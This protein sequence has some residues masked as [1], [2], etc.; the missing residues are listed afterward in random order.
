M[1]RSKTWIQMLK[2]NPRPKPTGYTTVDDAYDTRIPLHN[3]E[4]F[5]HGINFRAKFIGSLEVPRPSSRVEIVASMRRIRYEFRAKSIRK[6]KCHITISVDGVKVLKRR[7]RDDRRRKRGMHVDESEIM[8]MNHPIY[9][10]FYVSHDSLDLKIFSYIVRD[11]PENTFKCNVFKALKK[12][13]ALHI[14]R[15]LG[16][17]F[18]VCHKL[19]SQERQQRSS[20]QATSPSVEN[21]NENEEAPSVTVAEPPSCEGTA[22]IE[23]SSEDQTDGAGATEEQHVPVGLLGEGNEGTSAALMEMSGTDEDLIKLDLKHTILAPQPSEPLIIRPSTHVG[24]SQQAST[25][26]P[27]PEHAPSGKPNQTG[28]PSKPPNINLLNLKMWSPADISLHRAATGRQQTG[29]SV[30]PNPGAGD[31]TDMFRPVPSNPLNPFKETEAEGES[32]LVQ[33]LEEQLQAERASR[34]ELEEQL[35]AERAEKLQLETQLKTEK[36]DR[37]EAQARVHHLLVQNQK[38]LSHVHKLMVDLQDLQ[39][40]QATGPFQSGIPVTSNGTMIDTLK[41]IQQDHS[42]SETTPLVDVTQNDS[43]V[44]RQQMPLIVNADAGTPGNLSPDGFEVAVGADTDVNSP[45][46]DVTDFDR[47]VN[48]WEQ[49]DDN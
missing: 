48:S 37:I 33:R 30:A 42:M 7:R 25:P 18:E 35:T 3:E 40:L 6:A 4:A 43:D 8:M 14:V 16:Q 11:G 21:G 19:Q 36:T 46:P 49:L 29:T 44:G 24:L 45:F 47:K 22:P 27:L 38:L 20:E 1:N 15:T 10:I 13:Q 41:T 12:S 34:T 39:T 23:P 2:R 31:E 32:E 17:A 5:K 9:R 26:L 28:L